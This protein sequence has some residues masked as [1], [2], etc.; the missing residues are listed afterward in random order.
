MTLDI[1]SMVMVVEF[2]SWTDGIQKCCIAIIS[3][4]GFFYIL[5]DKL[6]QI[7]QKLVIFS[8]KANFYAKKLL[9]L[10][11]NYFCIRIPSFLLD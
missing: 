6:V 11:K 4:K 5:L 1:I 8:I 10:P 2:H 7:R 9:N 3:L